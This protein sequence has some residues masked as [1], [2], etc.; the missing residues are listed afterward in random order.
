[1]NASISFFL[2]CHGISIFPLR[3]IK[4]SCAIAPDQRQLNLDAAAPILFAASA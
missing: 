1:M 3:Q 4:D 2:S